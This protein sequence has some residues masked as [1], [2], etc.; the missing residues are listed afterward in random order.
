LIGFH[1]MFIFGF[2]IPKLYIL[3]ILFIRV[4]I[5]SK[6][7]SEWSILGI[8]Q[9]LLGLFCGVLCITFVLLKVCYRNILV[10]H[11]HVPYWT[12][13][14]LF[15]IIGIVFLLVQ[16]NIRCA[17]LNLENLFVVIADTYCRCHVKF[18]NVPRI[19]N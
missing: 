7:F 9:T 5:I 12:N 14:I 15:A 8:Q 10:S 11:M 18:Y 2:A 16:K 17:K 19:G 3:T 6:M 13:H 1:F 4:T